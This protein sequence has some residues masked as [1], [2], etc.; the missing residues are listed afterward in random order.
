MYRILKADKDTYITDKI[1]KGVRKF[2]SNVGSAATLDLFKLNGMTYSGS[3]PALEKSRLLIHFDLNPIKE[4]VQN[5]KLDYSSPSFWC[6]MNLK[7]V[8]GGQPTPSNFTVSVF[9]LSASFEE[10][11]GRDVVFFSDYDVSNWITASSGINWF[12]TGCSSP[13][14]VQSGNG[15]YITGSFSLAN[16]E[17]QQYFKTGEEDLLVDV[18]SIISATLAGE[19]PDEGFRISF[20][21]SIEN[22]SNTYFVKRFGSSVS[23]D[24]TKRPR[25]IYGFDD[26]ITDDSQNLVFD[27]SCNLILRNYSAGSLTNIVS[28]STFVEITDSNC[29]LLKLLTSPVQGG[30]ELYFTGSQYSYS[31]S[32]SAFVNGTYVAHVNISSSDTNI[33]QILNVSSSISFTPVWTSLDGTV[34]YSSGSIV[35]FNKPL[36]TSS[37]LSM[38]HY[39]VN[40]L[41]VKDSYK[42]SDSPSLVNV[43][44]FDQTNPLLTV[45]KTPTEVAG[46]VVND[47]FYEI[48]D[49][50]TEEIVIPHDAIK[51]STKISADSR[52]MYFE[53]DPGSLHVNHSYIIDVVLVTNGRK[54]KYK[55]VSQTFKIE[56]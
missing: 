29:L 30:Y 22:N 37:A 49:S 48:R 35:T 38:N 12:V 56:S 25:L 55:N 17:V 18:T 28:G 26:S 31:N 40:V 45:V 52:G 9:P 13:C 15:D 33:A 32:T 50:S 24:E 46:V 36:R 43:Q 5:K 54:V 1:V 7:D 19:I 34:V 2:K 51:N 3:L 21:E 53:F 23:Y 27:K 41:N 14:N 20:E 42:Q 39:V 11:I 10:G 6:K 4:L 8:Y 16:T 44:I 47:A